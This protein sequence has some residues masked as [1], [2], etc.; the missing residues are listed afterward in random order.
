M[1][2]AFSLTPLFVCLYQLLC[3]VPRLP[4][5]LL[6]ML[7]PLLQLLP[8]P[9]SLLPNVTRILSR[10]WSQ[11]RR[12]RGEQLRTLTITQCGRVSKWTKKKEWSRRKRKRQNLQP[13]Q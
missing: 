11:R 8:R 7:L 2:Q 5:L 4:L 10:T 1:L 12:Q 6:L 9:V 3:L 13:R